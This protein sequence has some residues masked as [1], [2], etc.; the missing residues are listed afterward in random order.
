MAR[1]A[2]MTILLAL[3]LALGACTGG[4]SD[5]ADAGGTG[6]ASVAAPPEQPIRTTSLFLSPADVAAMRAAVESSQHVRVAAARTIAKAEAAM[7]GSPSVPPADVEEARDIYEAGLADGHDAR[8]LAMAYALTGE[9]RYAQ[10]ARELVLAWATGYE[11]SLDSGHYVYEPV[12]PAIKLLMAYDLIAHSPAMSEADRAVVVEWARGFIETNRRRVEGAYNHPWVPEAPWGNGAA[13]ARAMLVTAA[14]VADDEEA[15]RWAVEENTMDDGQ[16]YTWY[17]M[18]EHSMGASGRMVEQ[19][20]RHSLG[21]AAYT[22]QPLTLIAE[23]M[24]H[25]G[26]D[27]YAYETES[28]KSLQLGWEYLAPYFA[29]TAEYPYE[30][31]PDAFFADRSI[32]LDARYEPFNTLEYTFSEVRATMEIPLARTGSDAL[33]R[34]IRA[35][36]EPRGEHRDGHITGFTAL[37]SATAG[38]EAVAG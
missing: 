37:W 8:S 28:G 13:W 32:H 38:V 24:R 36:D 31:A 17:T 1:A 26:L 27:L 35:G 4:G 19:D 5:G 6:S 11:S 20:V 30:E 16:P 7:T 22:L 14:A 18:I 25:R 2:L 29:G 23:V 34:A 12:G 10:K 3:L 15:L 9:E 21:Y 33:A